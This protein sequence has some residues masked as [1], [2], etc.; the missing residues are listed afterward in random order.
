MLPFVLSAVGL[1]LW[2]CEQSAQPG[3]AAD[4]GAALDVDP[5]E[6]DGT[7]IPDAWDDTATEASEGSCWMEGVADFACPARPKGLRPDEC[8]TGELDDGSGFAPGTG[9][10]LPQTPSDCA[11]GECDLRPTGSRPEACSSGRVFDDP[12]FLPGT[13]TCIPDLEDWDCP[14]GWRSVEATLDETGSPIAGTEDVP[15]R[16]CEPPPMPSSCPAATIA[17]PGEPACHPLGQSCPTPDERWPSDDTIRTMAPG[18]DGPIVFVAPDGTG[19]GSRLDPMSL[20]LATYLFDDVPSGAIIALAL[21]DYPETAELD[22]GVALV[23]ACVQGTRLT[24]VGGYLDVGAIT[25]T[26]ELPS[27]AANLSIEA[28]TNGVV[29]RGGATGSP[30]HR[31]HNVGIGSAFQR[32]VAVTDG[33]QLQLSDVRISG[34]SLDPDPIYLETGILSGGG[35]VASYGASVTGENIMIDSVAHAGLWVDALDGRQTRVDL[36]RLFIDS[37]SLH[38]SS[39]WSTG[40]GVM[41]GTAVSL[42]DTTILHAGLSASSNQ[43]SEGIVA[44][45]VSLSL[46]NVLVHGSGPSPVL[47]DGIALSDV[48]AVIDN[49]VVSDVAGAA[50]SAVWGQ[51][52]LTGFA[53]LRCAYDPFASACLVLDGAEAD[54]RRVVVGQSE[55]TG[56]AIGDSSGLLPNVS[57]SEL[58]VAESSFGLVIDSD[59][60]V[61]HLVVAGSRWLGLQ[62]SG[63]T[64]RMDTALFADSGQSAIYAQPGLLPVNVA[65]RSLTLLRG[66]DGIDLMLPWD[67]TLPPPELTLERALLRDQQGAAIL[68]DQSLLHLSDVV[69]VGSG[70]PA[71]SLG[72]S[73]ADGERLFALESPE[74]PA[75]SSLPLLDITYSSMRFRGLTLLHSLR[76]GAILYDSD[77]TLDAA[78]VDAPAEM[79]LQ[80][81]A[82]RGIS[83][84]AGT[85]LKLSNAII[86][87]SDEVGLFADAAS[88][89]ELDRSILRDNRDSIV[90]LGGAVALDNITVTRESFATT[91]DADLLLGEGFGRLY[92]E[93]GVVTANSL[94]SAAP[95]QFTLGASG[96]ITGLILR[97]P[98]EGTEMPLLL[99]DADAVVSVE[100]AVFERASVAQAAGS[101]FALRDAVFRSPAGGWRLQGADGVT[102]VGL[103]ERVRLDGAWVPNEAQTQLLADGIVAERGSNLTLQDI[104]IVAFDRSGLVAADSGSSVSAERLVVQA[105]GAINA[106]PARISATERG[107]TAGIRVEGAS[108]TLQGASLRENEAT[109]LHVR[110]PLASLAFHQLDIDRTLAVEDDLRQL[111]FGDGL[112]LGDGAT[113]DGTALRLREN[114]RCGLQL[115]GAG[116]SLQLR[117]ALIRRNFIGINLMGS[118]LT[119]TELATAV[120]DERYEENGLDLGSSDLEIPDIEAA[121][122]ELT[123]SDPNEA[124]PLGNQRED[125]SNG[126]DDNGDGAMD[127]EDEQCTLRPVCSTAP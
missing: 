27:L 96:S 6:T 109:A 3:S 104:S 10:C 103:G 46:A 2:G 122:A 99:L 31:L 76:P 60:T 125:C 43:T 13:G 85:R 102:T 57:L 67:S 110:G 34:V 42:R 15:F 41:G 86:A 70:G 40:V 107:R 61:N 123:T 65:A 38:P 52:E 55:R 58:L 88:S 33:G 53:A 118:D 117:D 7:E 74:T 29:V 97:N 100:R 101:D 24:P 71:L 30:I 119:R 48:T 111:Q 32:G 91:P 17:V 126:E 20:N 93:G 89:I 12:G 112:V 80:R 66:A 22:D 4:T 84:E 87:R 90:A 49:L 108:V 79:R 39:L 47:T 77:V 54:V 69:V 51:L 37:P 19:V 26:G 56:I 115:Y 127:C 81:V 23:G 105:I 8:E 116:T 124:A 18:F 14:A 83:A 44:A 59:V 82:G 92:L 5:G 9:V 16:R 45:P 75:G 25:M 28:V 98:P 78:M 62:V 36:A 64:T 68:A 94:Q 114:P 63:G 72:S 50:L 73:D 95:L 120:R 21:G 1:L 121:L 11:T 113:L 106:S 35:L